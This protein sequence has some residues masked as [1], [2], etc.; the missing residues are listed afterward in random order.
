MD[1]FHLY[2]KIYLS[3]ELTAAYEDACNKLG[4]NPAQPSANVEG[5]VVRDQMAR[6][7]LNAAQLGECNTAVLSELAVAFGMRNWRLM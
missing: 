7:L 2:E 1:R 3:T 4:I 6:A 5:E